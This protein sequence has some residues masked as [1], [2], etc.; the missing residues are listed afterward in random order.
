MKRAAKRKDII[1][2]VDILSFSSAV[3]TAIE[4]NGIIHPCP[5]T[6]DT[7]ALAR[8]IDGEAAVAR[9]D[10]PARGRFSLSPPTFENIEKGQRVVL[11][12]PNGAACASSAREGSTV[13]IGSFLNC[14]AVAGVVSKLLENSDLRVTVIA[15]GEREKDGTSSDCFRPAIEDYLGA[16][17]IISALDYSLSP[18]ADVCCRT[19]NRCHVLL[20]DLLWGCESGLELQEMGFGN[21]IR[22][23]SRSNIYNSV[24]VLHDGRIIRRN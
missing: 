4:H 3:A 17:S 21:D 1:V 7:V 18:E 23:C 15:C 5:M 20:N 6:T 24:P 13:F 14:D 19:F 12:S 11:A 10:V 8:S 9:R 22:F 16:G 2:V